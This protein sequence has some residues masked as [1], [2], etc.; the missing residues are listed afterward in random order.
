V[1][2]LSTGEGE[3]V[4]RSRGVGGAVLVLPLVLYR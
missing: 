4:K 3:M 1:P 2:V